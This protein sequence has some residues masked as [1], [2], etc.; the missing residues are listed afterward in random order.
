MLII[1]LMLAMFLAAI[2]GT[3]VTLAIPTIVGDLQGFD[4]IS[5]VFSV[6]LLTSA[7]ATPIYGKLSDLYGRKRTLNVGIIIF[8]LGCL[9]AG[10]SQNMVMLIISRAVQGIGAGSIFTVPFTI[11]G[12]T[13]PLEERGK[14]QGAMGMV[15]GI[16]GLVGPFIGG[17]LID[18][19]SW[20]W[21][22]FINIPFGILALVV[23]DRSLKET[24]HVKRQHID[25]PG[26]VVLSLAMLALLSVFVF[27][28]NDGV[29]LDF[30][31]V[32][33]VV[34]S[35]LLFVVFA[36]IER[37]S[38]EPIVAFTL[39]NRSSVLVNAVAFFIAA[40]LIGLDVYLP[41][42]LQN[43]EGLS[44]LLAGLALL[45]MSVSWFLASRFIGKAI[46]RFGGRAVTVVALFVSLLTVLPLLLFARGSSIPFVVLIVFAQGFGI[47]AAFTALTIIVQESVTF[48]Q[49]GSAIAIN[50]LLKNL[51]QTIAISVYGGVF[52]MQI[53]HGFEREG[54]TQFDLGNL[55]DM[56][57][58]Q[59]GVTWSQIVGVLSDSLHI[60]FMVIIAVVVLALLLAVIMPR[61]QAVR[62]ED[63][64]Q[65]DALSA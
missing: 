10:L 23:L 22:F 4:I 45:P 36:R 33:P 28:E 60:L 34:L 2:E 1:A 52:N 41:L 46:L 15:W 5:L 37:R 18:T 27:G 11:V 31:T 14:A 3:I 55:Y 30:Y 40:A 62:P 50:S 47:G 57:V 25:F 19:L 43:V 56:A 39:F 26:I 8:L 59:A 7:I 61:T 13:F 51:G 9:C 35:V 65:V 32:G 53:I 54:I 49:R 48:E 12:D 38:P 16:A 58:Y 44:P 20:H 63:Q 64:E 42:Y 29:H 17:L 21:I 6:Y 24:V